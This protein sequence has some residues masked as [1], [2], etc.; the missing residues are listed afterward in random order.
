MSMLNRHPADKGHPCPICGKTDFCWFAEYPSGPVVMCGRVS[1]E[2]EVAG[3]DGLTYVFKKKTNQNY[4]MYEEI[5]QNKAAKLEWMKTQPWYKPAKSSKSYN[6]TSTAAPA[7][8]I[9]MENIVVDEVKPLSNDRLNEI[10]SFML[11]QL[12]LEPAHKTA[13]LDEWNAGIDPELGEK[14]LSLWPIKSLPLSDRLL[15]KGW[16][17]ANITRKEL[18]DRMVYKFGSLRGVPGFFKQTDKS[19]NSHWQITGL[20]GIIFPEYDSQ[21]NI[22]RLRIGD[23]HCSVREYATDRQGKYI[24]ET[25]NGVEKKAFCASYDFNYLT[26]L[27]ERTPYVNG[28]PEA[29]KK[30]VVYDPAPNGIKTVALSAKGYPKLD[31]K[32]D[33]K[34]KNFSS[35]SDAV[36]TKIV[37]KDGH[38]VKQFLHY[39]K[40]P[41]GTQSGSNI[42]L[43]TKSGDDNKF[44]Y[45]TEGEKKAI[46]INSVLN[47]P[48]V[49]LPGVQTYPK[50][51][52]KEW[53]KDKSL[54]DCQ[55]EKGL[56]AIVIVY[57]ADKAT[58]DMVLS[59][60]KGAVK[61][62]LDKGIDTYVGEWNVLHGKGADDVLIQGLDL[63]YVKKVLE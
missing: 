50:L 38:K 26:G 25:V 48:V 11:E 21:G 40:Y 13:L 46:V 19:G 33:G 32:T 9:E 20:S 62:C 27:W 41:E 6:K 63:N 52:E 17:T 30:T 54:I 5:E 56:V 37:E 31:G 18:I 4:S 58:N 53:L 60:E 39:N 1:E 14:I 61:T 35:R 8:P 45:V 12:V 15:S 29:D 3:Q 49:S 7:K 51:F 42:S 22:Y 16:K 59:C 10:Y 23:E 44:L 24:Y 55:H 47:V 34:Y 28:V 36:E 43:Y 2:G 57:D